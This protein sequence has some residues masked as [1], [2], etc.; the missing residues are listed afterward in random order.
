[1]LDRWFG[2]LRLLDKFSAVLPAENPRFGCSLY[3]PLALFLNITY[4]WL[5]T[6]IINCFKSFTL[7]VRPLKSITTKQTFW[8]FC[9][10]DSR[11]TRDLIMVNICFVTAPIFNLR[12]RFA[13]VPILLQL[14]DM[15]VKGTNTP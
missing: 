8:L 10:K 15:D 1:M 3:K 11:S 14:D 2:P 9:L 7:V 13:T 4:L 12:P 5:S 6:Y